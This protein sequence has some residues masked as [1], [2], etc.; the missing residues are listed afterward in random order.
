MPA[1]N[2]HEHDVDAEYLYPADAVVTDI[3]QT[4]GQLYVTVAVPCPECDEVL[5][6]DADVETI[7]ESEREFDLPLEDADDVYD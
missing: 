1:A 3:Y 4:D 7:A 5:D 2:A 6:L